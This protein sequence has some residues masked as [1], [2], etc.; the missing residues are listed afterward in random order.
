MPR[1]K[2]LPPHKYSKI[3]D[4]TQASPVRNRPAGCAIPPYQI[5]YAPCRLSSSITSGAKP[6]SHTLLPPQVSHQAQIR[7][8][9]HFSLLKCH[10]RKMPTCPSPQAV[11]SRTVSLRS[12]PPLTRSPLLWCRGWH[13]FSEGTAC[14]LSE[15]SQCITSGAKSPSNTL[16]PPHLTHKET[17]NLPSTALCGTFQFPQCVTSGA[18]MPSHALFSPHLTHQESGKLIFR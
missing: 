4:I 18:K 6:P 8:S 14:R 15:D 10:I 1:H 12:T 7:P 13:R 5:L 3:P 11:P 17:T 9:V 16:F 2:L